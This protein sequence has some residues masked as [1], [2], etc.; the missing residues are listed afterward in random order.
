LDARS[1]STLRPTLPIFALGRR[2]GAT[3]TAAAL[4]DSLR[5]VAAG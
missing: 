1:P 2:D 4:Q 5:D 3:N